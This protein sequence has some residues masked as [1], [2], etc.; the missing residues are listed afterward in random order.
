[1]KP[2]I[3]RR[4]DRF[5]DKHRIGE[6]HFAALEFPELGDMGGTWE[7]WL[8]GFAAAVERVKG[9]DVPVYAPEKLRKAYKNVADQAKRLLVATNPIKE[10]GRPDPELAAAAEVVIERYDKL[11][12]SVPQ[13]KEP[14]GG[15]GQT[16]KFYEQ[17]AAEDAFD[18][19]IGWAQ[20]PNDSPSGQYV[21]LT[22]LILE[23]AGRKPKSV[24]QR[25]KMHVG[26]KRREGHGT[27]KRLRADM[28]QIMDL[29]D[30]AV[31]VEET[32]KNI[33]IGGYTAKSV[34]D[35]AHRQ[36]LE[37]RAKKKE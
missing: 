30:S 6:A 37:S 36:F 3:Q 29:A 24:L 20:L 26:K 32:L 7:A 27:V 15:R 10:L 33:S 14:R 34:F 4:V 16:P 12:A 28:R 21:E 13:K 19:L 23:A 5:I 2:E 35:L 25:C 17:I 8:D 22:T 9:A 31:T 11:A 18:L 1:M